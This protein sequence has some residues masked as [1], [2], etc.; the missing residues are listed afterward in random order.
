MKA[1]TVKELARLSGV[2]VRTLHHYDEIGLL[3]PALVGENRYRYYGREELLRL[4]DILFHR[5]PAFPSRRLP[6][7]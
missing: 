4:Q 6:E 2:T 7:R 3:K 5:E 1:Y